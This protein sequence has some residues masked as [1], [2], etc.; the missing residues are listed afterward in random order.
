MTAPAPRDDL[1]T[2]PATPGYVLA[3]LRNVL[4]NDEEAYDW[5]GDELT[6][7]ITVAEFMGSWPHMDPPA[8]GGTMNVV[9]GLDVPDG[10]WVA[11]LEPA[12]QRTV[13]EVCEFLAARVRRPVVRP[14][15]IAGVRCAKAGAFRAIVDVLTGTGLTDGEAGTIAPSTPL[16][17]YLWR[18][19]GAF[20]FELTKL[21]PGAIPEPT[22]E[23]PPP[24]GAM[25]GV[26][27]GP[28]VMVAA[29]LTGW[30]PGVVLA[31]VGTLLCYLVAWVSGEHRVPPPVAGLGN[32]RTFRD[33]AETLAAAEPA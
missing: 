9:W 5:P 30:L 23:F 4:R 28:V 20:R 12:E 16:A 2:V 13:G 21:A 7:D 17:D 14:A 24:S 6:A 11:V 26:A 18:Y 3:V 19:Q 32:L 25:I 10:E 1:R 29:I 22:F 8:L 31:C 27:V 15:D 33:L